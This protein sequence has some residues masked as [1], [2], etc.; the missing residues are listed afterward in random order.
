VIGHAGD[1][2]F[3]PLVTFDA[4]DLDATARAEAAFDAVMA[5]ALRLGGTVTGEHGV[6]VLKIPHFARQVGP[7]VLD[8]TRRIKEALDPLDIL[9]PGKWV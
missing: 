1:G 9:N 6:G 3:H 2:N 7:D 5:A 4:S 8:V